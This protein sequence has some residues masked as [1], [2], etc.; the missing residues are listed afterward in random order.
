[1]ERNGN[2]NG[3]KPKQ[4]TVCFN[5]GALVSGRHGHKV[6]IQFEQISVRLLSFQVG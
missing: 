4:R 3:S 2:K 1:M 6:C 5:Q